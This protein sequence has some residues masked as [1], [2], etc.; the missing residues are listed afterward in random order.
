MNWDHVDPVGASYVGDRRPDFMFANDHWYVGTHIDYGPDGALY[1]ADWHDDT[2]CH[3]REDVEWDRTNGRIFR[4]HYG[5]FKPA[6]VN[7]GKMSDT[8]LVA[9][10]TH[11]N[12]WFV[13]MA[14]RLLQ[15]RAATR[16]LAGD[17][18]ASLQALLNSKHPVPLRLD[19]LGTS[20]ACGL[21]TVESLEAL[22]SD[23][24]L[25]SSRAE[26]LLA[27]SNLLRPLVISGGLGRRELAS[28]LRQVPTETARFI[29]AGLISTRTQSEDPLVVK[30]TWYGTEPLIAADPAWGLQVARTSKDPAFRGWI[31][32]RIAA[33]PKIAPCFSMPCR[34]IL[35][36]SSPPWP[37]SSRR[38]LRS[39]L[40]P[41][42]PKF[43][44]PSS[45]PPAG[46][47]SQA[48]SPLPRRQ[49]PGSAN[50]P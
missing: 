26:R 16:Q 50:S 13:R 24:E 38:R 44:I 48:R 11:R 35:A 29:A 41:P 28:A 2:T 10:H 18:I 14:R 3:R 47:G 17:A 45:L 21:T 43:T 25:V 6:A 5:E 19:A 49:I 20:Y 31:Y 34:K 36:Q 4:V 8:E 15:E 33:I 1:F 22:R 37:S 7:L 46:P 39:K 23:E 30:L 42:G 9:L 32:R 27:E 40:P 12:Q